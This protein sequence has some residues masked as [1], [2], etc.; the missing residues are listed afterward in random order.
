M[1][2]FGDEEPLSMPA[3]S[4]DRQ[5]LDKLLQD[6]KL[7]HKSKDFMDLLDFV[8]RLRH[9]APFN[10]MLLQVQKKGLTYAASEHDWLRRFGR[11]V[12]LDARPLLIMWPF[13]PVALVYDVVDTEGTELPK[14]IESFYARGPVTRAEVVAYYSLMA[15]KRIMAAEVDE[16]DSSAGRIQCITRSRSDK[17]FSH[18]R[19]VVNRNHRPETQFATLIH[20]LGHL[21]LGHLGQDPKL[22][23]RNRSTLSQ[24]QEELEAESVSY[25]VCKRQGVASKSEAYLSNYV[26]EHTTIEQMDCYQVMR[27]AGQIESML[28]ISVKTQFA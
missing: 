23:V 9:F 7:Y 8:A 16:G 24:R 26:K 3:V 6:S 25:L 20:E 4:A 5:L 27:A 14:A 10:A 18:Y 22:H 11:K 21:F 1:H 17:E 19:V 15:R 13:G 2:F 12:K 28:G